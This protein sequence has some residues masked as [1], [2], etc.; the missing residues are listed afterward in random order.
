MEVGGS[1]HDIRGIESRRTWSKGE[2]D[3][4]LLILNEVVASGQR[5]DTGSFKPGTITMIERRLAE[6]CPNSGLRA[7][8]HIES[9]LKKWKKQYGIIYDMLNKSGFGWND[10][11]KCVDVD[12]DEVWK[13][14]VQSNPSA[15]AWRSKPFPLYERLASIFGKDRATGHG[16]Q[17]PID[18]VNDL[19]LK[20]GNE[21]FNDVCSPM[22][23]NEIHSEP[24]TRP[25]SKGKRKSGMKDDD[26]VSGFGN[27][28][29]KLFDKLAAK[30]D[31]SE[32]N[33]PQYLAME[34]DRLG[35]SVD[36]NLEISKAMRLDPSN[37]EVFK[38]IRTDTGKIEFARKFLNY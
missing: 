14:Y 24:S 38:I 29:E 15:K 25:K 8:P 18:M 9:K 37:V 30:L 16:A 6:I 26:I 17:T 20:S 5:C 36:D 27:V 3:A 22:S 34:L 19:N 23:V 1:S 32:A 35:F 2:E 13:A 33:Y 21:Q 7:N 31:K 4:L 12:S 28:A 11:L 10:S